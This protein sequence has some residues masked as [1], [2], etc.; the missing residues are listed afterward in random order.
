DQVRQMFDQVSRQAAE[1]GLDYDFD[2]IVVANS[3][4]AHRFLHFAHAHGLMPE[5]KEALL[6]GHFEK[7]RDIGDIAHLAEVGAPL[8][9]D[10]ARFRR[11][12]ES[13]EFTAEVRADISEARALG[14]T[15]VPFFVIDRRY[16][17]SGVSRRRSSPNPSRPPGTRIRRSPC[18][19]TAAAT[20]AGKATQ[21]RSAAPTT[22]TEARACDSSPRS[23]PQISTLGQQRHTSGQQSDTPRCRRRR[24]GHRALSMIAVASP[25]TE[26]RRA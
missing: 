8:G 9:L 22:A 24:S 1:E 23:P 6:S 4:T 2:A 19:P 26:T 15:G 16:A 17:I 7:G 13:E 18:S 11:V 5:A 21:A 10:A 25:S 20:T 12:S 14:A 3:F